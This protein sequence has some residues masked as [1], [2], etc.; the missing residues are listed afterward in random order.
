[1]LVL[2]WIHNYKWFLQIWSHMPEEPYFTISKQ[3]DYFEVMGFP[4]LQQTTCIFYLWKTVLY[5]AFYAGWAFYYICARGILMKWRLEVTQ[6]LASFDL[7]HTQNIVC[8]CKHLSCLH[9]LAVRIK[10]SFNQHTPEIILKPN[11]VHMVTNLKKSLDKQ[12][13]FLSFVHT[14]HT[15]LSR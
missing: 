11:P 2:Q 9:I 7:A 8:S 13:Q 4:T 6:L 3:L 1:L 10:A 15:G 14:N 5:I 12:I